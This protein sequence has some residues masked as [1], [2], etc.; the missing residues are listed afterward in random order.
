MTN[1]PQQLDLIDYISHLPP[2]KT[3]T[4]PKT[5]VRRTDPRTSIDAACSLEAGG[6]EEKVYEVIKSFGVK[7]CISDDV[8]VAM[9]PI[10]VQT[11]TPRYAKLIAKGYIEDTGETRKGAS[12]RG[13]R[14]MR[15]IG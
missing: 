11:V 4:E 13:Q 2:I 14:V 15:A 10:G 6:L 7:G 8:V 12:G 9:M 1:Q 5:L 3:H